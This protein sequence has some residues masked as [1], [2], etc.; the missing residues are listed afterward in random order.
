MYSPGNGGSM[1]D[2]KR[3]K[4]KHLTL[5]DRYEI[6]KGLREHRNFREISEIIGCSPD[7]ISKELRKH[8]YLKRRNAYGLKLAKP[9]RCKHRDTCRK[10]DVC[11]KKKGHKCR[12]PCRE[13]LKCNELCSNF[14]DSPCKVGSKAPYVC[15]GCPKSSKCLF[16]K[17]FYSAEYAN[18]EYQQELHESRK[19]IN[20]TRD[21]LAAL[22]ELISPLILKGQPLS[23]IVEHHKEEIPCGE[24]TLYNYL[25]SG[26]LTAKSIDMRR[27]VRYKKRRKKVIQIRNNSKKEGHRY[28]DYLKFREENPN[29][30]VVQMD[31]VE[32]VKG[33]KLFQTMLWPENNLMLIFLI[34]SKEMKNTVTTIDWLEE[35]LGIEMFKEMFPV[36]L[37][38]NGTEFAD[39]EEFET[40]IN[41]GKRTN[42]FYCEPRHSEQKGEL[43]KN[44]EYIR[45]IL[46]K[47]KSFDELT[48]EQVLLI[49]NHINNTTRPKLHGLT[50]MKEAL[51]SFDKNAME[52]LGLNI[53]LPNDICLTPEL[54][55]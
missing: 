42:I 3:K 1:L 5:L 27:V 19:G 32:G 2:E 13:C 21:E 6:Q 4:G 11:N 20:L 50:P 30:R 26:Y 10:K 31:T 36:I 7:T 33:G 39:P 38:D 34:E 40:G 45:Y 54:I 8:R 28:S 47:G 37:T 17:Y 25:T 53:I 18:R 55:K 52:K 43:E 12:I 35:T 46:P 22:D 9:N 48:N 29:V 15:N 41:G 24:R 44:H 16:D 49:T 14:V 51:K 23:H